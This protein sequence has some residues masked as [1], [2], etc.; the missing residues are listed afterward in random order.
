M[1]FGSGPRRKLLLPV[2]HVDD[3]DKPEH[4]ASQALLAMKH[5]ADGVILCSWPASIRVM[6]E[7]LDA[8]NAALPHTLIGANFL[9]AASELKGVRLNGR[10][11]ILWTDSGVNGHGTESSLV[12]TDSILRESGF[13]GLLFGS[14]AFKGRSYVSKEDMPRLAGEARSRMDVQTTSGSSTG[15]AMAPQRAASVRAALGSDA[16]VAIASGVTVENVSELLP[17]TDIVMVG[18][19]VE[20]WREADEDLAALDVSARIAAMVDRY[21]TSGAVHQGRLDPARVAALA[22]VVHGYRS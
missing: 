6:L 20:A 4:T 15:V 12:E 17:S 10:C 5:G 2:L 11:E 3:D 22:A 18:T 21:G 9:C 8:V 1:L 14:F 19:G 13:R 7:A 16:V